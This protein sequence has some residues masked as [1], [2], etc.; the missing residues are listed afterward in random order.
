[1]K[2]PRWFQAKR[3]SL[4]VGLLLLIVLNIT[5]CSNNGGSTN[6]P[7]TTAIA[8]STPTT[9]AG[10]TPQVRLGIQACPDAVKDPSYWDPIVG[11]QSGVSKVGRVICANLIGQPSLQALILVGYGGTGKIVDAYVYNNITKPSPTQ[12]F[13]L[14]GLY[15]GDALIS[16]YNTI[17]TAEVDQASSLNKGQPSVAQTPDLFREFK[18]SD[19]AGT[20][21]PVAFPGIYPDLTRYQAETLQRQV[22]QG[23]Q[24][25]RLSAT[26]TSQSLAANLLKWSASSPATLVSGGGLHD[27]NAV[28]SVKSTSAGGSTITVT[29]SRL[30][31]NTNGG[32]WEATSVTSPGMTITSPQDRDRLTSP[33]TVTGKGNS[34]EGVIGKVVILDHLY[35]DI[36]R[37]NATG[38]SGNNA[39]FTASVTYTSTF[40]TGSQEGLVALF[41]YSAADSTISGAVIVKEMLS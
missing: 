35:T 33:T 27:P 2:T 25:W 23:Q 40:K 37:A 17:I 10:S 24:P 7:T 1:M 18:W 14:Q 15:K 28:V 34:F 8:G 6:T 26:Q 36:G 41:S 20:L 13:K 31:G 4:S 39:A 29:L 22:N 30:E 11:T 5:A 19:G 21:V 12:L 38:L 3:I 9:A 32:I 16:G